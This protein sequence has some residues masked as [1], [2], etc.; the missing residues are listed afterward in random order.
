[1][2]VSQGNKGVLKKKVWE[3][4]A[5]SL[6]MLFKTTGVFHFCSSLRHWIAVEAKQTNEVWAK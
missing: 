5:F 1:M 6:W 2:K 4:K 3:E